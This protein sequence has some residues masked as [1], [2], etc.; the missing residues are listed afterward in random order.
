MEILAE[1]FQKQVIHIFGIAGYWEGEGDRVGDH[2]KITIRREVAE[3]EKF[4]CS[5]DMVVHLSKKLETN[6][7]PKLFFKGLPLKCLD[8]QQAE[9]KT[10]KLVTIEGLPVSS[11]GFST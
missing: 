4:Q 7:S 9:L 10:T 6:K 1:N 11:K 5:S 2:T 8:L 3:G